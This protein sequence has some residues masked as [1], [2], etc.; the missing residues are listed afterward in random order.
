MKTTHQK[1]KKE[2]IQYAKDLRK[3]LNEWDFIGIYPFK[4]GPKDEY[5]CLINPILSHLHKNITEEELNNFLIKE[6]DE[7]FG[8]NPLKF[9]KIEDVVEKI[10]A[11]WNT[12]KTIK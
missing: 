9:T 10:I 3:I 11:W 2:Y 8:L 5:D 6:L 1:L 4:G 7:H 12:K